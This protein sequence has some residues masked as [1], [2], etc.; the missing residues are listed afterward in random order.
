MYQVQSKNCDSETEVVKIA[1]SID[2]EVGF[3]YRPIEGWALV[4][5]EVNVCLAIAMMLGEA[6]RRFG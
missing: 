2:L 4:E 5:V 1:E 3:G 6:V